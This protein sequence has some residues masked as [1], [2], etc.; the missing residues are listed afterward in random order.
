MP[1]KTLKDTTVKTT[2][3]E[4]HVDKGSL[5]PTS[6]PTSFEK[7]YLVS[8]HSGK[9]NAEK[10]AITND[11]ISLSE[12]PSPIPGRLF[13]SKKPLNSLNSK[14]HSDSEIKQLAKSKPDKPNL[15]DKC[16]QKKLCQNTKRKNPSDTESSNAH[17]KTNQDCGFS[18]KSTERPQLCAEE[19]PRYFEDDYNYLDL[20]FKRAKERYVYDL[21]PCFSD[22]KQF[23]ELYDKKQTQS[24]ILDLD[25]EIDGIFDKYSNSWTIY[26]RNVFNVSVKLYLRNKA[27]SRANVDK[28]CWVIVDNKL[29]KIESFSVSLIAKRT[30]SDKEVSLIQ[31]YGNREHMSSSL[32]RLLPLQPSCTSEDFC[33]LQKKNQVRF[34]RIRFGTSTMVRRCGQGS[35]EMFKLDLNIHA[36]LSHKRIL[37]ASA[38][39]VHLKVRSKTPAYYQDAV[40]RYSFKNAICPISLPSFCLDPISSPLVT[41]SDL[42]R[43]DAVAF[44]NH[45]AYIRSDIKKHI[46]GADEG[47]WLAT[48]NQIIKEALYKHQKRVPG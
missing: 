23:Y 29:E 24:Y 22:T 30:N 2:R 4:K 45:Q 35:K 47:R 6:I 21:K 19:I 7:S 25:P 12:P 20:T 9:S 16:S 26:R 37:I 1:T 38:T 42:I 27:I 11:A 14:E 18:I 40:W 41:T 36:N 10:S 34:K 5:N 31:L 28:P 3:K 8:N 43:L 15:D 13:L 39:S 46:E 44:Y 33:L 48:S 32:D 17:N